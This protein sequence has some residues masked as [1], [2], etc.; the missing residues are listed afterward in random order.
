[1]GDYKRIVASN[2]NGTLENDMS[3]NPRFQ[4]HY[5]ARFGEDAYGLARKPRHE[6]A[7]H[8]HSIVRGRNNAIRE[9]ICVPHFQERAQDLIAGIQ[10]AGFKFVIYSGAPAA[11]S[12]RFY[13]DEHGIPIDGAYETEGADRTDPQ[14]F[15]AVGKL[16]EPDGYSLKSYLTHKPEHAIAAE[17]AWG[18]AL[19]SQN[20]GS[21]LDEGRHGNIYVFSWEG[22]DADRIQEINA[23]LR[24]EL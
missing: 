13:Q 12:L 14:T 20:Q 7:L 17:T 15:R 23:F 1:M 11:R 5:I 3:R 21:D 9:E 24:G 8:E 6:L 19:L 22:L 16:M 18:K 2:R 4:H 10:G